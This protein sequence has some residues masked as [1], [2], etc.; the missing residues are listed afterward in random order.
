[1]LRGGALLCSAHGDAGANFARLF[2]GIDVD[3]T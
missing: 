1:V 2:V 3:A